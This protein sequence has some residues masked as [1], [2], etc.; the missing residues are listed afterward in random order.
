MTNVEMLDSKIKESGLTITFIAAKL[1]ISRQTFYKKKNGDWP[2]NQYEIEKLCNILN[3][4]SLKDK[5][6]IFFSH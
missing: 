4:T 2:F 6:S 1:G 5:E 3:I